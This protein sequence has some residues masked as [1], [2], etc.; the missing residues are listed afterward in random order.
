MAFTLNPSWFWEI[1]IYPIIR[2][3]L[4][5]TDISWAYCYYLVN[6][7][8]PAI[9]IWQLPKKV[10]VPITARI[11]SSS[12]LVT[13]QRFLHGVKQ[14]KVNFINEC[15]FWRPHKTARYKEITAHKIYKPLRS[16]EL[17]VQYNWESKENP[18]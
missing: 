5:M 15:I 2:N 18:V 9:Q 16:S 10:V 8:L 11:C 7:W 3:C 4:M 17:P 13:P 12:N 14:S 6:K 1:A